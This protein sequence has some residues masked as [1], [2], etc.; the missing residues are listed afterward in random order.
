MGEA[1]SLRWDDINFEKKTITVSKNNIMIKK[2]DSK[3]NVI[4]GYQLQT[5]D[6]TKTSNGNRAIP[7]NKS[8]ESALIELKKGHY[9]ICYSQLP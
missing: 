9:T 2:R 6:S 4:G 8:T 3:G 5:Q 7:I 1:L